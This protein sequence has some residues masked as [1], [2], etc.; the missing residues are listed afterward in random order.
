MFYSDGC[1]DYLLSLL[2]HID[3]VQVAGE[4]RAPFIL[5][6]VPSGERAAPFPDLGRT[7]CASRSGT[8]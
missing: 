3:G 5:F 7:G 6:R 2:R 1:G 4:L 8:R